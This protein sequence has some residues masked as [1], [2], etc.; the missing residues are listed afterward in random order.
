M[1][2]DQLDVDEVHEYLE[3]NPVMTANSD[4]EA[5]LPPIVASAPE[6][7]VEDLRVLIVDENPQGA[8]DLR[9]FANE[10]V[11][12]GG[13]T[14]IVRAPHAV[15]ASSEDVSRAALDMAE[16]EMMLPIRDYPDGFNAFL[17]V[18]DGYSVPWQ[19]GSILVALSIAVVF[20]VLCV[21][22]WRRSHS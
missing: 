13:G 10:L 11:D 5:V 9:N 4:L 6:R 2:L 18:V 16:R 17:D 22:W 14:V 7:G 15:S 20:A 19:N 21:V 12:A 8:T 3:T 1:K